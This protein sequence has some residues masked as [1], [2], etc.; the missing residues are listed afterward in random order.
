[1]TERDI[2]ITIGAVADKHP[3]QDAT[4]VPVLHFAYCKALDCP[5][6]RC[7]SVKAANFAR[8]VLKR[9]CGDDPSGIM[10]GWPEEK[11][12]RHLW[13]ITLTMRPTRG[14][15]AQIGADYHAMPD[16][17][18]EQRGDMMAIFRAFQTAMRAGGK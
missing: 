11:D 12:W 3:P 8:A 7:T 9:I 2:S 16:C 5:D 14:N 6:G 17:P 4:S 18:L 13:H 1:M 15:K 10:E